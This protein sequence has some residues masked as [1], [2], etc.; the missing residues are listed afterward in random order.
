MIL[1]ELK[2]QLET[3]ET[4]VFYGIVDNKMMNTLWNYIVFN[5]N[6]IKIKDS[7]TGFTDVYSVTLVRENFIPDGEIDKMIQ[8]ITSIPGMR[9]AGSDGVFNYTEKPGSN[10]VIELFTIDFVKPR[11]A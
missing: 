4:N 7:K 6:A 2:T 5:R 11:K 9:I 8:A 3:I 10:T 1:D